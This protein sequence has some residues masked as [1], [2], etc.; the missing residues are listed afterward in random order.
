MNY[1]RISTRLYTQPPLKFPKELKGLKSFSVSFIPKKC[2]CNI[3]IENDNLWIKHKDF[4]SK[5]FIPN[6]EDIGKPLSF[7][8]QKYFSKEKSEKFIYS[9]CWGSVVLRNEAWLKFEN[10]ISFYKK[11]DS[12]NKD[13][14][15]YVTAEE[16]LKLFCSKENIDSPAVIIEYER[17][18][19]RITDILKYNY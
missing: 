13:Y 8:L 2:T 17:F 3:Y 16:M 7:I 19:E 15:L 4:F 9:D 12:Y 10:V 1:L 11:Q 14:N 5:V 18:F 6:K